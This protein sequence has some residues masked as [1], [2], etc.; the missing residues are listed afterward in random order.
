MAESPALARPTAF[1]LAIT[2]NNK[3]TDS[4]LVNPL[5]Y[6]EYPSLNNFGLELRL[7]YPVEFKKLLFFFM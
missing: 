5:M 6:L 7:S 1:N 4:G 2:I 3:T